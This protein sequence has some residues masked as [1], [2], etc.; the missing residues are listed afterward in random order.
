M[1][2]TKSDWLEVLA[3]RIPGLG[4]IFS[5]CSG[6]CFTASRF[7][8]EQMPTVNPVVPV[9]YSSVVHAIVCMLVCLCQGSNLLADKSEWLLL[10]VRSIGGFS[11]FVLVYYAFHFMNFSDANTIAMSAPIF[12]A[13]LAAVFLR[14]PCGV[15]QAVAILLT[16]SGLVLIARPS[17]IFGDITGAKF[18]ASQYII[19]ASMAFGASLGVAV[20]ILTLRGIRKTE[21]FVVIVW[22][23]WLSV[24]FGVG[25]LLILHYA[26]GE[27]I[28]Y[29]S[30]TSDWWY[31]NLCAIC[32]MLAQ[33]FFVWALRVEEAGLVSLARTFDIVVAFVFQ[34]AFMDQPIHWTSI[35]GSVI[36]STTVVI[37]CLKKVYDSNPASFCCSKKNSYDVTIK[38]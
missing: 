3:T 25:L 20:S 10:V 18:N 37:T 35:V 13:P 9:V 36:V 26:T 19:G 17:I 24:V 7:G 30:T 32:G 33:A 34:I 6:I 11:T 2:A 5:V 29:P 12:V 1:V 15:F 28:G 38:E 16:S 31:I 8:S 4:I 23:S 21:P 22:F 14:E 27:V